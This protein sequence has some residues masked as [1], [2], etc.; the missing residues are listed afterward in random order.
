MGVNRIRRRR[1]GELPSAEPP[2]GSAQNEAAE[3]E[4]RLL[5]IGAPEFTDLI[6]NAL[7]WTGGLI[8]ADVTPN[9]KQATPEA[10]AIKTPP[11]K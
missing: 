10:D 8:E 4:E 6:V 1:V 5:A 9:I 3:V 2:A 7:K 11:K